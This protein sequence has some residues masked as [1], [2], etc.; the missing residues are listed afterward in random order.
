MIVV[1][2]FIILVVRKDL[3]FMVSSIIRTVL[4]IQYGYALPVCIYSGPQT[5]N[6]NI[7]LIDLYAVSNMTQVDSRPAHF[8]A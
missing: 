1:V 2:T 6:S 4:K 5:L 7:V 8:V 3:T